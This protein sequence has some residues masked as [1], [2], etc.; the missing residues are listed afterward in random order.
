[1]HRTPGSRIKDYDHASK[2]IGAFSSVEDFWALYVRLKPL[3]ALPPVSDYHLFRAGV[4]PTY[5]DP[6]NIRGGK[7]QVRLRKGIA[8]RIWEDL[9]LAIIGDQ[10]HGPLAEADTPE[11]LCGA[12]I[13]IRHTEDVLSVWNRTSR[14]GAATLKIR[15][16]MRK[17]LG[18]GPDV[19]F[20]YV[21]HSDRLGK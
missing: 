11:E 1:M 21:A 9:V 4:K 10:F 16:L 13:S 19:V 20:E 14:H 7:W 17:V 18:F 8:A 6:A 15:N 2:R 5:E 3:D 12:V